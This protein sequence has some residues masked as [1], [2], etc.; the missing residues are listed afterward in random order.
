[1]TEKREITRIMGCGLLIL[2][3]ITTWAYPVD[4][5]LGATFIAGGLVLYLITNEGA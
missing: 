2:F 1:M 5:R 4:Y 3:G